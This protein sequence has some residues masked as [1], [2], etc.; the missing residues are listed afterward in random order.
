MQNRDG[1]KYIHRGQVHCQTVVVTQRRVG[2][3]HKTEIHVLHHLAQPVL[4]KRI[5]IRLGMLHEG[6]PHALLNNVLHT[7]EPFPNCVATVENDQ[8]AVTPLTGGPPNTSKES[9]L[10]TLMAGFPKTFDGECRPM[11]GPPCHFRLIKGATP[12]AIRRSRPVAEPLLPRLKEELAAS[13]SKESS[14]G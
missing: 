2:T 11:K 10:K 4:S 12:D 7:A 6:Y 3:I 8:P 1:W 9:T 14:G 5:Q 13:R